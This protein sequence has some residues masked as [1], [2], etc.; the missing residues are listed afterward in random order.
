MK[1]ILKWGVILGVLVEVW[2]YVYVSAGWHRSPATFNLFWIVF[3]IQI[4][5]LVLAL[6]ATAAEGRGYG[7]QLVA[8]TLVS[9]IG[10]ILV[11]IGS[12]LCMTVVF[13]NYAREVLAMQEQALR[14]AGKSEEEIRQLVQMA[15]KTGSPAVS[16]IAGCIGTIVTGFVSSLVIA[17]F[18]RAKQPQSGASQAQPA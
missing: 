5:V 4:V 15:A 2:S 1:T 12:Y 16:A 13:P 17:A 18:V 8:G 14:A 11:V 3:P 7:G 10:G 6:R 9:I